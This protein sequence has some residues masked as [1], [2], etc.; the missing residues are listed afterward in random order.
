MS[1]SI[2]PSV[3]SF[4]PSILN[5]EVS[6]RIVSHRSKSMKIKFELANDVSEATDVVLVIATPR[7]ITSVPFQIRP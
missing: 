4:P 5:T 7:G 1:Y 2:T 6:K 3:I